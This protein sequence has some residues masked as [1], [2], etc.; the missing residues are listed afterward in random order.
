METGRKICI[1]DVGSTTSKAILLSFRDQNIVFVDSSEAPTTVESPCED[2]KFG[3]YNAIRKLEAKSGEVILSPACDAGTMS[4]DPNCTYLSTSSA[5]GGLQ[6]LVIGLT[7]FD[8]ASSAKR[9]A[10]GAGG[11]ILDTFAIDDKRTAI[12]QMLAMKNQHPDMILLCGGTDGGAISGVIRLAEILRLADVQ[13]KYRTTAKI[14]LIY[15]GNAD[16]A[17]LIT[18]TMGQQFDLFVLP[19]LRP[20]LTAENLQPTQQKV[21]KLFMENVMERAPG[22][23]ELKLLVASDIIPTPVGVLNTL[24]ELSSGIDKNILSFDIGGATTDVFSFLQGN[25]QRTVSANLGMSYS[26]LNVLRECGIDSVLRW[27]PKEV[28]E[29][30]VRNYLANKTLHPTYQPSA[31]IEKAIEHAIAREAL[32]KA[33]QQHR[34]MHYNTEKIGFLDKLQGNKRDKFEAQFSYVKDEKKYTFYESDFD[35][36]IGAGGIFTHATV[37]QTISILIDSIA[38]QGVT[39]LWRDK[40]FIT[41]HLGVLATTQPKS[42]QQLISTDCFEPLCLLLKPLLEHKKDRNVV[43]Y[44]EMETGGVKQFTEIISNQLYYFEAKPDTDILF[45]CKDKGCIFKGEVSFKTRT[46]LP[47]VIDTRQE[48]WKHVNESNMLLASYDFSL[49]QK[50][51]CP[52]ETSSLEIVSGKFLRTQTLPYMGDILIAENE[53]VRP[54]DQVAVN[55]YEPPRLYLVNTFPGY[56]HSDQ[57]MFDASLK[58]K[59]GE[60]VDLDDL[61]FVV[62]D[63]FRKQYPDLPASKCYSPVRGKLDSI[64]YKANTLVFSEIQD[65][66]SEPVTVNV[67]AQMSIAPKKII[68]YLKK[69]IGDFVYRGEVLAQNMRPKGGAAAPIILKAPSTGR[70]VKIDREQGTL[71]LHYD[72]K[73]HYYEAHVS[74]IVTG[75]SPKKSIDIEFEADKLDGKLGFGT[76]CHGIFRYFASWAEVKASDVA[77]TAIYCPELLSNEQLNSLKEKNIKALIVDTISERELIRFLGFEPGVINSGNEILDYSIIILSGFGCAIRESNGAVVLKKYNGQQVYCEPHTRI[78]AGVIRPALYF[79]RS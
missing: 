63:R 24:K 51:I 60:K 47:L 10:Y 38:P 76:N 48:P 21:Q 61:I 55:R 79:I 57:E 74:G 64:E 71:T 14:P 19:N 5:G 7:L 3:V 43:A 69:D 34:E 27:L 49:D 58:I 66:S 17:E 41:P 59:L 70:V 32:S 33:L 72:K 56:K 78:R 2:V 23:S 50:R 40:H 67:A 46:S 28:G 6:I 30:M 39:E 29:E 36:L 73:P 9:A 4:I 45:T 37:G 16:A 25:S 11:V 53:H 54:G 22:Y 77:G 62:P 12:N 68:G 20:S 1:T 65:Y 44:L 52:S 75:V 15:A 35:I 26:A 31:D 18:K 42:V 13:P 8:S